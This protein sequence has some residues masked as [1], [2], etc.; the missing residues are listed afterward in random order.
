MQCTVVDK[1]K[2]LDVGN[3]IAAQRWAVFKKIK[4]NTLSLNIYPGLK[5][6]DGETIDPSKVPGLMEAG[7]IPNASNLEHRPEPRQRGPLYILLKKIIAELLVSLFS[8]FY[9]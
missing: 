5:F 6:K 8:F 3:I 1:V 4:D 7:W 2:Y 9:P